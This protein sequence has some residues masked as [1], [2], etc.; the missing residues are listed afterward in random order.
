MK[1][2]TFAGTVACARL[3][4]TRNF[5][6]LRFE[7]RNYSGG[8]GSGFGVQA[9]FHRQSGRAFGVWLSGRTKKGSI[10]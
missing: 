4:F 9:G 5:E 10:P 8:K 2:G 7:I 6:I 1:G 3:R